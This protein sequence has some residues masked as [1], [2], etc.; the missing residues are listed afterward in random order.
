MNRLLVIAATGVFA[1]Y[2]FGAGTVNSYRTGLEYEFK[3]GWVAFWTSRAVF[4]RIEY[5]DV[6]ISF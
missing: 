5:P 2:L 1:C 4:A 6:S 3:R